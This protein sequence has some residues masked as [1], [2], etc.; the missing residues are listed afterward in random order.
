MNSE[1]YSKQSFLPQLGENG[2]EILNDAS[3]L[4]IGAGGLGTTL[5]YDLAC[6][7]VGTI[8]IADHEIVR[9]TNLNNQFIHFEDDIGSLK[10]SSASRKLRQFNSM[11]NV[12]PH[13]TAVN[14]DNVIEIISQY[15][16]VALAIEDTQTMMLVNEA[17]VELNKPFVV[18]GI[19]GFAGTIMFVQPHETP[20]LSCLYGTDMPPEENNGAIGSV[21]STISSMEA[22]AVI[23]YLL[24]LPVPASGKLFY[25]D[26]CKGTLD[27]TPIDLKEDC[28]VCGK[29]ADD[30]AYFEEAD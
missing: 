3:V 28:P 7:G 11:I 27:A 16:I 19:N 23:Q 20:C 14:K 10:V 26:A 12:I 29:D 24:G 1:R 21:V 30:D 25:Y 6:A 22:T 18:S 2:Q 4:V 5:L 8:G 13:A 9:I 15:D 17:C